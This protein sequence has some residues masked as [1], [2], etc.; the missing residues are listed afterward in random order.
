MS[1]SSDES[2]GNSPEAG[3]GNGEVLWQQATML[4]GPDILVEKF[5]ELSELEE[6]YPSAPP[7]PG[8]TEG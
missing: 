3:D 7:L 2:A 6:S 4:L 8:T 1:A 5:P